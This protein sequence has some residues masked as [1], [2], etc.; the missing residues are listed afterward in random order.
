MLREL[1]TTGSKVKR[2]C[3]LGVILVSLIK[4]NMQY[5]FNF[6]LIFAQ[7]TDEEAER[8]KY[9]LIQFSQFN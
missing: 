8:R 6:N 5:W 7:L 1:K 9:E 4:S 3:A 2:R